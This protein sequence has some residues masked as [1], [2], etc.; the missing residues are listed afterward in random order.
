MQTLP[1]VGEQA[2]VAGISFPLTVE[3][4][5][6]SDRTASL[7]GEHPQNGMEVLLPRVCLTLLHT[8]RRSLNSSLIS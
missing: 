6:Q 2:F 7:K 4:Y 8:S 3:K 5:N 1:Q